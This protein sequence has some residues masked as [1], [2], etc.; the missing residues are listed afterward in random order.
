MII[1]FHTHIFP[2]DLAEKT[3]PWMMSFT[4][5]QYQ[6]NG[7]GQ[8]LRA[9]M[10]RSGVD[11]SVT[12]P[13]VTRVGTMRKIND[14]AASQA[15]QWGFVSFGSVHPD[16]PNWRDE[17]KRFK[18]LGLVGLKLHHDYQD[19]WFDTKEN[20]AIIEAAFEEGL[21][22]LVHPGSDPVSPSIH[23]CSSKMIRDALPLLTQGTFIAAHLGGHMMI[24]EAMENVIGEDLYIDISMAEVYY[25]P[26]AIRPLILA[27]DPDKILFGTDSPWVDQAR[28]IAG[29]RSMQ[30][31][32]ELENKILG[33]NAERLL[34]L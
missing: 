7:T 12:L 21:P 33:G 11:L 5:I 9:S 17:L 23:R 34:G 32:V 22:V 19:F 30:L 24:E 10:E 29:V 8:G 2:K 1:D 25:P 20:Y 26:E 15:K 18:E 4:G 13:I 27:H 28:S 16:E 3:L 14:Y 6:T 31:G